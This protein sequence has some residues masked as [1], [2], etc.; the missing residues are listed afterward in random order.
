MDQ[1]ALVRQETAMAVEEFL[2]AN[3]KELKGRK[4]KFGARYLEK[5]RAE[6]ES[7]IFEEKKLEHE[8]KRRRLKEVMDLVDHLSQRESGNRSRLNKELLE[9]KENLLSDLKTLSLQSQE[10]KE[11]ITKDMKPKPIK[12]LSWA[13]GDDH[14]LK[15]ACF[16]LQTR[17]NYKKVYQSICH[18]DYLRELESLQWE[19][20]EMERA[21]EKLRQT[22]KEICATINTV[23]K[24]LK[25]RTNTFLSERG[26]LSER[27]KRK[28]DKCQ[29]DS[30][31]GVEGVFLSEDLSTFAT[32]LSVRETQPTISD[33]TGKVEQENFVTVVSKEEVLKESPCNVPTRRT[34]H[35]EGEKILSRIKCLQ[36]ENPEEPH[37]CFEIMS[38]GIQFYKK[39]TESGQVFDPLSKSERKSPESCGYVRRLL[40]FNADE[41]SLEVWRNFDK[42][43]TRIPL[44]SV[45]SLLIPLASQILLN[46]REREKKTNDKVSPG[47]SKTSQKVFFPFE[48]VIERKEAEV[49]QLV[50]IAPQFWALKHIICFYNHFILANDE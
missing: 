3:E 19:V 2:Q 7:D 27:K 50:C 17:S 5:L 11:S 21:E 8:G 16:P 25:D 14:V 37:T 40:R 45:S 4:F 10:I 38:K 46:I 47:L 9:V 15:E 48:L 31:K 12:S 1:L 13:I 23:Y 34:G 33:A 26:I 6:I 36:S 28:K 35:V 18:G 49:E 39:V 30:Y 43:E 42:I 41:E 22:L 20:T 24:S 44:R 29:Q 32:S